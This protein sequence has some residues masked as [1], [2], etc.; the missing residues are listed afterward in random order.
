MPDW[1]P[2]R[3]HR[4]SP[5]GPLIGVFLLVFVFLPLLGSVAWV[6]FRMLRGPYGWVIL[7]AG[8]LVLLGFA[9]FAR[10]MFGR[11]WG[12]VGRLIDATQRLGDG[13]T[14][15]RIPTPQPGP[16][17]AIGASFNRMAA[18]LEE[19]DERRRR[20]LADLGHEL[21]TPLTVI[22]GEIEAVIDGLHD[23]VS[24][25]TV[26][27]EVDLMERLLDDLRLLSLAEAGRLQLY[28]EPTDVGEL[29]EDV[30]ASFAATLEAQQVKSAISVAESARTITADPHRLRQVLG[31]LV[32]NALKQMPDGGTLTVTSRRDGEMVVIEVADTGPGIPADRLD[33]VFDRFVKAGDTAGTGLG[34]SIAR[35]LVEA[36]GGTIA[37]SNRPEGGAV[38]TI[39]LPIATAPAPSPA[40]M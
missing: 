21:R 40:T 18:R 8:I 5:L 34:L 36:H 20:L 38:F 13:E 28:L 24:L 32:S 22:R 19:E 10:R 6:G 11:T 26:I 15:V 1:E 33:Q 31:N 3:G 12:P 30:I 35:D 9:L 39:S 16:F 17:G 2:H 14:G 25:H 37:A 27:D 23:P 29:I 4:R 7:G